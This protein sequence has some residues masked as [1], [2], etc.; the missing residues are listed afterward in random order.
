MTMH[1]N[2]REQHIIIPVDRLSPE[3]LG[4]LIEEFVTRSGTDYG[5]REASLDEKCAAIRK[6]LTSGRAVII[7]DPASQ[8][9]NIV[10]SEDVQRPAANRPKK[11][12]P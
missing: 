10:L 9:C 8:T 1:D 12:T 4:G 7:C 11:G 6:Q 2:S 3:A 5:Q